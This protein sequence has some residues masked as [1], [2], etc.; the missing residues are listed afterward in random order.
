MVSTLSDDV[1]RASSHFT[2][3]I[4]ND[5]GIRWLV[6]YIDVVLLKM[7]VKLIA[8]LM[9]RS[10]YSKIVDESQQFRISNSPETVRWTVSMKTF[11]STIC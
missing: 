9:E 11:D 8:M 3:A 4:G 1:P 2:S 10:S 6:V 7:A 5:V